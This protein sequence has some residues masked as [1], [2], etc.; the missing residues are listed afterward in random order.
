M[1][2]AWQWSR[3]EA[4]S[5]D[6]PALECLEETL[7]SNLRGRRIDRAAC[8]LQHRL[9]RNVRAEPGANSAFHMSEFDEYLVG[10]LRVSAVIRRPVSCHMNPFRPGTLDTGLCSFADFG[11]SNRTY[12]RLV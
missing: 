10:V 8:E 12:V 7:G 3:R 1:A 5:A 11:M 6:T 4:C 9:G 2:A